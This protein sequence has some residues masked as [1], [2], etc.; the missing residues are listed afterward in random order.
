V[1]LTGGSGG[2]SDAVKDWAIAGADRAAQ[3]GHVAP[4]IGIIREKETPAKRAQEQRTRVLR[5][6]YNHER[7][8]LEAFVCDAAIAF[9]GGDGTIS[10]VAFCLALGR[11]IVLVGSEWSRRYPL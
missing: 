10:E 5:P 11:P 2:K 7:N 9:E 6:P 8:F 1:L 3:E 4:W